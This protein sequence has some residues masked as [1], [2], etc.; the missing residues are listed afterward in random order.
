[1]EGSGCTPISPVGV[2]SSSGK[3]ESLGRGERE[4]EG[5]GRESTPGEVLAG[6]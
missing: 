3:W 1:M 2:Q 4:R 6:R 5:G